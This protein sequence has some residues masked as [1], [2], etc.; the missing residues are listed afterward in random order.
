MEDARRFGGG[1]IKQTEEEIAFQRPSEPEDAWLMSL[2]DK[3]HAF[4]LVQGF[5]E[6]RQRRREQVH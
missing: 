6:D 2:E 5:L 3:L 4:R 1:M